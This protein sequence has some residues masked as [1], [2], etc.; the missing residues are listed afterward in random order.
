MGG[1][2]GVDLECGKNQAGCFYQP[3]L[4][5]HDTDTLRTLPNLEYRNGCAEIIKYGMI[6]SSDLLAALSAK[7]VSAQYEDVIA[8]CVE[9]KRRLVEEDE[10]DK[11]HRMLLNFGHTVGHAVE[12]CS[13]YT[14]PHGMAVS[15][16]ME[17]ITKAAAVLGFA[18]ES[19]SVTLHGLL[20]RYD[21]PV[22][23]G[24]PAEKLLEAAQNDKKTGGDVITIV[25]PKRAGECI[26]K[27][28]N[29]PE[30]MKWLL[31]GGVK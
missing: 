2:T 20:E 23:C 12:S 6:G 4:V 14:I 18:D 1:K 13:N 9:M 27:T 24:Y 19:V 7:P 16:G 26:L 22:R 11:G 17:I 28:I 29:K 25:V 8:A 15:I 31:A 5:I 10:F 21:L 3:A 30:L